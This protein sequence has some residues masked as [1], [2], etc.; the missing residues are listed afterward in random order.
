MSVKQASSPEAR[1]PGGRGIV[2]LVQEVISELKKTN[3]PTYQD[4]VRLTG[5]VLAVIFVF[6][7]FLFVMD[8]VLTQLWKFLMPIR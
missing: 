2:V 1:R 3:W 4:G 6:T 8:I 7:M 5:I